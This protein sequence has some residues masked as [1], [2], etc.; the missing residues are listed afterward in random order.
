VSTVS[1]AVP[2]PLS[3]R[4]LFRN[5]GL[6]SLALR[7][8]ADSRQATRRNHDLQKPQLAVNPREYAGWWA[9]RLCTCLSDRDRDFPSCSPRTVARSPTSVLLPWRSPA[10]FLYSSIYHKTTY[11]RPERKILQRLGS[12]GRPNPEAPIALVLSSQ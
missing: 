3:A 8:T 7:K 5:G 1:K 9:H 6:G 11:L 4:S 2:T 10:V 12:A